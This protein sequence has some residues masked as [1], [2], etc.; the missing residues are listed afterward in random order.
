MSNILVEVDKWET[1]GINLGL[2]KYK[3]KEI[4]R[5]KLGDI[6]LCRLDLIDLWLRSDIYASWEKLIEALTKMDDY[7]TTI[8]RIR[9]EFLQGG[10]P[11]GVR[12]RGMGPGGMGP[13][14][15]GPGGRNTSGSE[16]IYIHTCT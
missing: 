4:D 8:E 10:I 7:S 16:F 6:A 2:K 15:M 1:L 12:P 11:G 13:G 14:G 3:L 9:T 5:S